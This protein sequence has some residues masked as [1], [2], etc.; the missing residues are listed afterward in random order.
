MKRSESR[1]QASTGRTTIALHDAVEGARERYGQRG[2][3]ERSSPQS[4]SETAFV[5]TFL[6]VFLTPPSDS[7]DRLCLNGNYPSY[8]SRTSS[9]ISTYFPN[10]QNSPPFCAAHPGR[11]HHVDPA[12]LDGEEVWAGDATEILANV[13]NVVHRVH[14]K[15]SSIFFGLP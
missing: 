5:E 1:A 13:V 14:H 7:H 4:P 2:D 11:P 15:S 8:Q 9:I 12:L 3:G 6:E 10:T